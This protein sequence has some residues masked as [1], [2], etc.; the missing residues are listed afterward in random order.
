MTRGDRSEAD[1]VQRPTEFL[2]LRVFIDIDKLT[3]YKRL[4]LLTNTVGLPSLYCQKYNAIEW[5][6]FRS[7]FSIFYGIFNS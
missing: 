5:E 1:T 3:D 2:H 7:L 4:N 6:V